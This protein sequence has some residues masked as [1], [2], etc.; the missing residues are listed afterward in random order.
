MSQKSIRIFIN[1]TYSKG[2]KKNYPTKKTNIYRTDDVWTLD[3]LDL[4]D[5]GPE[6]IRNFK[7]VLVLVDNFSNFH[8]TIPLTSKKLKQ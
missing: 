1:E 5:Y 8:C 3:I 6:N 4:K 2:P 7:Y